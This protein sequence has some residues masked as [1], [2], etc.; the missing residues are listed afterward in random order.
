V[1]L[2]L[3]IPTTYM[4]STQDYSV[5][6][7]ITSNDTSTEQEVM[8][9]S[10]GGSDRSGVA[11]RAGTIGSG[12]YNGSD[13]VNISGDIIVSRSHHVVILHTAANTMSMY[14]DGIIQTGDI[15]NSWDDNNSCSISANNSAFDGAVDHLSIYNRVLPTSEINQLYH[16]PF[17]NILLPRRWY[18]PS[19][20]P[21]GAIPQIMDY[22]KQMRC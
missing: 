17:C 8:R 9:F 4:A 10:S 20:G 18:V 6:L 11:I 12:T 16:N 14:I 13:F 15:Q 22:Y 19:A 1:S 2:P 21:S 3:S 5:V 7:H